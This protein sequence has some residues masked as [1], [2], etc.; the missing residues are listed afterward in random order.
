M[1]LVLTHLSWYVSLLCTVQYD[2]KTFNL[3]QLPE[4]DDIDLSDVDLDDLGKDEL[5]VTDVMSHSKLPPN[6]YP[7]PM[8]EGPDDIPQIA[9]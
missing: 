4:E 3:L 6:P 9:V 7:S 2:F 5:W 8:E 1:H